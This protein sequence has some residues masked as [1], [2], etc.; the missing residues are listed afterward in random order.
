MYNGYMI[1]RN[2]SHTL[3]NAKKSILLLGPRQVGK[4]TLLESLNP[5]LVINLADEAEF[6]NF[7]ANPSELQSRIEEQNPSTIL[8]DE[9][10]RLPSLL[11][12]IQVIIDQNKKRQFFLSG[13]SARKLRRGSANLL[14]GRLFNYRLGPIS[15]LEVQFKMNTQKALEVGTL[16]EP[17]T[18]DRGFA[19]KH[20]RNYT[21][22]YLR[23]EII[24]ESLTRGIQ[25]FSRFLQKAAE[26]SG[27]F[28]DFSKLASRSKVNRSAARRYYE[29]LEDTLICDRVDAYQT[30]Q[31]DL[32]KHPKYFFFDNGVVNGVLG[33]FKASADRAGLL[34]EHLFFNQLKN[35][36]YCLDKDIR[37]SHF[38]T[39]GGLEVDFVI[40]IEDRICLVEVK[41]NT[42][43]ASELNP[44]VTARKYF[45]KLTEC[46]VA[47]GKTENKKTNNVRIMNW[48]EVIKAVFDV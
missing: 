27:Q 42:P 6:L 36:S 7:T 5:D 43:S 12:T 13:S 40:E 32:V 29:L 14:P 33:N 17:Y 39:R 38:R 11:N 9:V 35:T 28:L 2:L 47:C 44:I 18:E 22:T 31:C 20:L 10:Q 45:P 1:T 4:S 41:T 37:V 8:V 48:Q 3:R 25:G 46:F 15:C 19:E 23:E 34:L 26:H 30:E 16:P 24:A 21:A